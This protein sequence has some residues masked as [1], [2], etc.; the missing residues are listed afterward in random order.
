VGAMVRVDH[1]G[2]GVVPHAAG[3]EHVIG[4]GL[5]QYR[6]LPDLR[7]ASGLENVVRVALQ[8]AHVREVIGVIPIP[9]SEWQAGPRR[10]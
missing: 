6:F 8:E 1:G 3:P 10:P 4:P 2:L 9:E 7:R 5:L